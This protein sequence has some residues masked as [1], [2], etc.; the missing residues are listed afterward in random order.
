MYRLKRTLGG[1]LF[2]YAV[3][4]TAQV[5]FSRFYVD[6]LD[7]Q[8]IWDVFNYITGAGIL[9]AIGVAC[10][11]KRMTADDADPVRRLTAKVGCY[12]LP[13]PGHHLL[14]ALVLPPHGRH[15]VRRAERRLDA[16]FL[17]QPPRPRHRRRLS[18]EGGQGGID[19]RVTAV[20]YGARAPRAYCERAYCS[21]PAESLICAAPCRILWR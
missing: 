17:P 6:A 19:G 7:P 3:L 5:L 14:P 2:V 10:A 9:V 11:H 18:L 20:R 12:V 4:Y 21:R 8:E 13:R 1:L 15:A 16:R